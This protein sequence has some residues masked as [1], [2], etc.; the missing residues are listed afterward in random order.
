MENKL[1]WFVGASYGGKEDQTDRFIEEG[2]WEHNF[3]DSKTHEI[4][5]SMEVGDLIV[6]V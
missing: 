3:N 6:C 4:V 5:N 2:I 1:A